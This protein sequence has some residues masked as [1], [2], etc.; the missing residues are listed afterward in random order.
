[1]KICINYLLLACILITGIACK[2]AKT[3]NET[4]VVDEVKP[5]ESVAKDQGPATINDASKAI[6]EHEELQ[7]LDENK[8]PNDIYPLSVSFFSI[9]EG[10]DG[11]MMNRYKEFI[12][13]FSKEKKL[14]LANEQ[15]AWGREGEV[16]YC[17]LLEELN[18]K[19][20]IEFIEKSK[21]LLA[22]SKLV[23]VIENGRCH[24]KRR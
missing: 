16:D 18:A 15:N 8:Q 4:N 14:T 2:T 20:R 19:Q 6:V 12:D 3:K 22:E 5:T 10:T 23:H 9:G 1:M 7:P 11:K 24:P 21:S 17:F 13:I